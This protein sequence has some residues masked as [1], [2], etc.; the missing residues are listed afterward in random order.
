M[1][2]VR[3]RIQKDLEK[4]SLPGA[5]FVTDSS[6]EGAYLPAG[7]D[8]KVFTMVSGAPAWATPVTG[9]SFT[10]S[11]GTN[12]Q[13]VNAGD[14]LLAQAGNG[15]SVLVGATDKF[16]YAIR[17]STDADNAADIGT[18]GGLFV[19]VVNIVT[20]ASWNDSTN[21]LTITFTDG[22]TVNVPIVD[23]IGAFLSDWVMSDGTTTDTIN[24]HETVTFTGQNKIQ[25]TVTSSTNTLTIRI[26]VS[27]STAGQVL[28]STGSSSSPTW[29]TPSA[30][31]T[32][33]LPKKDEFT[34]SSAATTVTLSSTPSAVTGYTGIDVYRNGLLLQASAWSRSGTTI[35]FGQA[36]GASAGAQYSE[37]VVVRYYV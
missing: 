11:D 34:P 23:T 5:V 33:P 17:L 12:S 37:T 4:S 7:T 2:D 32:P 6:S 8:G 9:S 13:T 24:N 15:L 29:Q 3:L 25:T 1:A 10:L 20:G 30:G 36:F 16:T 28:T 27:G 18:D 26:D 14:T 31:F 35:T 21:T 22:S 19:P